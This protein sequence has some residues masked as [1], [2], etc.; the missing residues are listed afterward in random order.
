M[1]KL[2][3]KYK[4]AGIVLSQLDQTQVRQKDLFCDEKLESNSDMDMALDRI[5]EKFGK[6]TIKLGSEGY[7]KS[8][9]PK[10]NLAPPSYTTSIEDIPT[11]H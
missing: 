5:N 7:I 10:D 6:D 1:Y 11:A 8:W 2:G 3:F 9:R 4:K